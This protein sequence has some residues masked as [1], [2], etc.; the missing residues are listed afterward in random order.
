MLKRVLI[1]IDWDYFINSEI[2]EIVSLRE[3]YWN[4]HLRWYKE[5]MK[6]PAIELQY[7]LLTGY[8]SFW[9]ALRH[10]YSFNT[11]TVLFV[12]ES[13]KYSYYLSKRLNCSKV[14]SFDA[15]ADIGYGGYLTQGYYTH[16]ANW[17]GRL[18]YNRSIE[19][20]VIV[21]S[22]YTKEKQEEFN[23]NTS[24]KFARLNTLD[25]QM[26]DEAVACVHICRSGAWTPPWYDNALYTFI[27]TSGIKRKRGF[28]KARQWKPQL[29]DYSRVVELMLCS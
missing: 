5:Y 27:D 13:H 8:R 17:L 25:R 3:N 1:S 12:S 11:S 9:D 20:A 24:I 19:E 2:P 29:I 10:K 16:C 4:I 15:H 14:V 26:P 18:V 22:P 21:Y 28:L 23:K 6:N 7:K